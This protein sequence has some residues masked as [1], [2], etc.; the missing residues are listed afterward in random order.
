[1]NAVSLGDVVLE[2][3]AGSRVERISGY[4][5]LVSE[6][7]YKPVI[8][9]SARHEVDPKEIARIYA[10][11]AKNTDIEH[12]EV[13]IDEALSVPASSVV[14]LAAIRLGASFVVIL[15]DR[16]GKYLSHLIKRS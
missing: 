3:P 12:V 4:R 1:M 9:E 10:I 7:Q 14:C 8:L 16:G 2:P 13:F 11:R 5:D 6:F 15:M